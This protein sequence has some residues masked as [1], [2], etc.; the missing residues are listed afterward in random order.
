MKD[1]YKLIN[2]VM[3]LECK[4]ISFHREVIDLVHIAEDLRY[5]IKKIEANMDKEVK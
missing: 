5:E 4:I 1:L 2:E 3:D